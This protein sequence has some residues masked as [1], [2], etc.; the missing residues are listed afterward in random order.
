MGRMSQAGDPEQESTVVPF[1]PGKVNIVVPGARIS[2]AGGG[3]DTPGM[4]ARLAKVEAAVE[5]IQTD[6]GEIRIDI[7]DMRK[8]A[9]R[10]F[11]LVFAAIIASF[12]ILV[13]AMITG[14]L[15]L[16]TKFDNMQ[17]SIVGVEKAIIEL[18]SRLP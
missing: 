11:L 6:I 1:P 12:L 3:R 5:H 14:Y 15:R 9:K 13:S 7:R 4:E 17:A 8:E 18:G 16:E 2:L 10:D